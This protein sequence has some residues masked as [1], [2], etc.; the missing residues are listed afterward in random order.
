MSNPVCRNIIGMT[1]IIRSVLHTVSNPV[2]CLFNLAYDSVCDLCHTKHHISGN[3]ARPF[4][5]I[6]MCKE[7]IL[8]E[9]FASTHAEIYSQKVADMSM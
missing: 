2:R 3:L 7:N 4:C 1:N 5:Q 6:L 9:R 8:S